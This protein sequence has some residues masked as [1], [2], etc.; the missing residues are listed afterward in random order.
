MVKGKLE[1][2]ALTAFT[3]NGDYAAIL[4]ANG[5]AKIW[6]TKSGDLLAEWKSS[7]GDHDIRHSCIACSFTGKKRRK[8]LGTKNLL[9]SSRHR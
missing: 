6:N 1:E 2:P 4:S 8:G 9:I 3:H 5:T 7:D